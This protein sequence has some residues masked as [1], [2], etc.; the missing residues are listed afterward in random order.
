MLAGHPADCLE[1][2]VDALVELLDLFLQPP[3]PAP[4]DDVLPLSM[5]DT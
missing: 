1:E 3:C 2:R 5:I 4:D